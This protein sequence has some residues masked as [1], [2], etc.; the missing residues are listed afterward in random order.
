MTTTY[1]DANLYHDM[2]MGRSVT[3]ILHLLNQ[4]P[5]EWFSKKQA[6][7][8]TATDGLEF[9]AAKTAVQQI[10][11]LRTFLRYLGVEVRGPS[12]LFG[13]NGSVVK[14][15]ATPHS[16]L[17]KRHHALSYHY[18]REAVASKAVD[19]QTRTPQPSGHPK[20]ALGVSTSMG[21]SAT[22]TSILER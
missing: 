14:G 16:T 3:A 2:L 22:T 20:Q 9:V 19:F 5:V 21:L 18:T 8:E 13:D 6:T 10:I 7:V 1:V 12:R 11:G 15:G 17:K 4:T